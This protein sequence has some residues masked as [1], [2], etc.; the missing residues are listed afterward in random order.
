MLWRARQDR[1]SLPTTT[2]TIVPETRPGIL[3]KTKSLLGLT[4]I[5]VLVP[6]ATSQSKNNNILTN[7][8]SNV[9][10]CCMFHR[11]TRDVDSVMVNG[12]ASGGNSSKIA[13]SPPCVSIAAAAPVAESE[14]PGA[15]KGNVSLSQLSKMLFWNII[16]CNHRSLT[17]KWLKSEKRSRRQLRLQL[18]KRL[19]QRQ[20]TLLPRCRLL[21][22]R[23]VSAAVVMQPVRL[24]RTT[25]IRRNKLSKKTIIRLLKTRIIMVL[26]VHGIPKKSLYNIDLPVHRKRF[27]RIVLFIVAGNDR[28]VQLR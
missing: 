25:L 2:S 4:V 13:N 26:I 8:R 23:L 18:Q 27:G 14:N 9:L 12:D 24:R 3:V 6:T 11:P 16:S 22:H 7:S 19:Q 20:L 10:H 15:S 5:G 1:R 28:I 21:Q 17:L